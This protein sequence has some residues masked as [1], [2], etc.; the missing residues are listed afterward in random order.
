MNYIRMDN[1]DTSNGLGI[2]IVVWV[3]GCRHQCKGCHNPSTWD[4]KAGKPWNNEAI[5]KFTSMLE[6][7]LIKRVTLSGG[8]PLAYPNRL[9]VSRIVSLIREKR[10]DV[11]IWIYTGYVWEAVRDRKWLENVDILVDGRFRE[12]LKD[13]SLYFRG[14]R[15]QRVIDVQETLKRGRVVLLR[16]PK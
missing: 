7:P 2:G 4:F 8:D 5:D 10:P 3:A 14:S 16:L 15:N 6:N 13:I 9:E 12:D 1:Y 11:K